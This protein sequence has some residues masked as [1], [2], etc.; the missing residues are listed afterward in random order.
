MGQSRTGNKTIFIQARA[1]KEKIG[2]PDYLEN[3]DVMKLE[4][5]YAEV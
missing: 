5:D 4:K 3:D 1:M 2:Y